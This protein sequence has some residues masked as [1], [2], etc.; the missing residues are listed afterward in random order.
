MRTSNKYTTEL[1]QGAGM[2]NETL[3]LL[4]HY[5]IGMSKKE[6]TEKVIS[7]GILPSC[8]NIR[9]EHII[10]KVFY[11]RYVK[12][13]QNVPGWLQT[14][15][16]RGVM[17]SDFSQLIMIYCARVHR[18]YYDF[19]IECLNPLRASKSVKL[20]K[21]LSNE[22]MH[23]LVNECKA[24]WSEKMQLKNATYLRNTLA[25]FGQINS[26]DEI[27]EYRPS[28]FAFLY[29]LHELHFTGLSD[30]A[31]VNDTDWQLFGMTKED[32]IARIMDSNIKGGYIAQRSGDLITISW[33][34]KTMEEFIDAIL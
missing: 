9:T 28:D 10:D 7:E 26:K 12:T 1:S 14:V 3:L 4:P 24:K 18:V 13:N 22:F 25:A 5:V 15:R 30:A 23:N 33:K 19:I 20:P 16:E 29:L 21:E 34:Y 8:T 17:L 2:I 11:N 6:M 27:L 32:V 31:I